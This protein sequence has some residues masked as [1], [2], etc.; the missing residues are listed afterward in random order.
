MILTTNCFGSAT[1]LSLKE[2]RNASPTDAAP[3]DLLSSM[4]SISLP[5][6]L[7]RDSLIICMK[8]AWTILRG[9]GASELFMSS[10]ASAY[11]PM[12]SFGR[13][14]IIFWRSGLVPLRIAP[15]NLLTATFCA[16]TSASP[17]SPVK[18]NVCAYLIAAAKHERL[19]ALPSDVK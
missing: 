12:M 16:E 4:D 1:P 3:R 2:Q 5:S 7:P 11:S 18:S 13:P 10:S 8:C 15:V 14:C 19:S 9:I 6:P 17:S